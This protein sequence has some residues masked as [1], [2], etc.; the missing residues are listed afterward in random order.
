MDF[1]QNFLNKITADD[2]CSFLTDV[3]NWC[4]HRPL[5][6]LALEMSGRGDIFE[7]GCGEGSTKHLH[8]YGIKTGRC[9]I[10][11][12]YSMEWLQK[13][14]HTLSHV[15]PPVHEFVTTINPDVLTAMVDYFTNSN[16]T[17]V[18]LVD[19][20]PGERRWEDMAAIANKVDL[21]I[22]HDSELAATGYMLDKI[23]H[24]YKYRINI[25]TIGACAALVSN[26]ID[27][28]AFNNMKLGDFTLETNIK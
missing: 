20:S 2:T 3:D 1:D 14:A 27:V 18:C 8:D 23:W 22:I 17:T 7:L 5:L 4:N 15:T 19:H 16:K 26:T 10:S 25:N 12:D 24:L 9:V 6:Y 11:Y 13:Y 28:T 21:V